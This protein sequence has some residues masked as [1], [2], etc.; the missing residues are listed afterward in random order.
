MNRQEKEYHEARDEAL[1]TMLQNLLRELQ[2]ISA[3]TDTL[4]KLKMPEVSKANP[5]TSFHRYRPS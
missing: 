1:F 5:G 2:K 3:D 4:V